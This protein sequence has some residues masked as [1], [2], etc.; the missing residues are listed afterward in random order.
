MNPIK[1]NNLS[2]GNIP[3]VV[4]TI[5]SHKCLEMFTS[6]CTDFCDIAEV[7]LDEIG[8]FHGWVACCQT[9]EAAGIPVMLTLRNSKEGGKCTL[10]DQERLKILSEGLECCSI[11]DVELQSNLTE[12]ISP[13]VKAAGKSLL[14][15]YHDFSGTP[16]EAELE[17]KI[18]DASEYADIIKIATMVTADIDLLTLN[19]VL[20]K[21]RNIPLCLIGM[22][23][24][25]TRTRTSFPCMGSALTYGYLDFVSAPGQLPARNL[26]DHLRTVHPGYNEDFIIRH[27]I[28]ECV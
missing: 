25:G 13:I 15:S 28:F 27:E 23:S 14:V 6:E 16:S 11:F 19:H 1:V 20:S 5:S 4:G 8:I 17:D 24:K 21:T 18:A 26:V 2:V 22:S 10:T 3:R 7:R 9:I 12:T